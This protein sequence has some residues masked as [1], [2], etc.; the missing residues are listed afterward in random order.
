MNDTEPAVNDTEPVVA[1]DAGA[2]IANETEPVIATDISPTDAANRGATNAVESNELTEG[3][4]HFTGWSTKDVSLPF[5]VGE[6]VEVFWTEETPPEWFAGTVKDVFIKRV[7]KYETLRM[8]TMRIILAC[9]AGYWEY[10]ACFLLDCLNAFQST[11]TDLKGSEEPELYCWPAPGF[12]KR[13][14]TGVRMVCKVLA[15]IAKAEDSPPQQP[16]VGYAMLGT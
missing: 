13:S 5:A 3:E 12:E 11:R 1:D 4:E 9:K 14:A 16:P 8:T 15:A 2:V 6:R 10:F 7:Y